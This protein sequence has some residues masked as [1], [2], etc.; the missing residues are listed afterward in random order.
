[1]AIMGLLSFLRPACK[2]SPE[3]VSEGHFSFGTD[4]GAPW[5][6]EL[7]VIATWL[8]LSPCSLLEVHAGKMESVLSVPRE[9]LVTECLGPSASSYCLLVTKDFF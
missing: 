8:L 7:L 1:M 4:G 5:C 9:G 2:V 3:L 6:L